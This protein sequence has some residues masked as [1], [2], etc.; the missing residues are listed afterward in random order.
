MSVKYHKKIRAI[1]F[2][3]NGFNIQGY[4]RIDYINNILKICDIP[5]EIV[6][7]L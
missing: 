5:H 2:L 7:E 1:I 4:N 3:E 6:L